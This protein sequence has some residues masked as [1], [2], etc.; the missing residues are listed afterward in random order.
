MTSTMVNVQCA[1][2]GNMTT[3]SQDR[4][5]SSGQLYCSECLVYTNCLYCGQQLVLNRTTFEEVDR[6]PLCIDCHDE[7]TASHNDHTSK[8][9]YGVWID[10][11]KRTGNGLVDHLK[12][13]GARLLGIFLVLTLIRV[14]VGFVA[15]LVIEPFTIVNLAV[16]PVLVF[17]GYLCYKGGDW[18]MTYQ[19]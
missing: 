9:S 3:A 11:L 14:I 12:W 4:I 1:D 17:L 5:E 19:P 2:C 10:C 15:I 16:L 7:P 18:A 6:N 13:A 8:R